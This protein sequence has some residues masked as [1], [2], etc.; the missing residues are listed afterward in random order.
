MSNEELAQ[1][2]ANMLAECKSIAA[3]IDPRLDVEHDEA[4]DGKYFYIRNRHQLWPKR[5]L[6]IF[7]HERQRFCKPDNNPRW[8]EGSFFKACEFAVTMLLKNQ[9]L[10][11]V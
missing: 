5:E 8:T 6:V 11:H 4:F 7:N 1:A 9:G 10:N 3:S 2:F